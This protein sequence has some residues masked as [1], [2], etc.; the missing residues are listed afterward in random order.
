MT[1]ITENLKQLRLKKY[2]IAIEYVNS[3]L[4]KG[5]DTEP[6]KVP[7]DFLEDKLE[8]GHRI[9]IHEAIIDRKKWKRVPG[10]RIRLD[11]TYVKDKILPI[12]YDKKQKDLFCRILKLSQ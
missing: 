7:L 5:K 6:V 3:C 2:R 9:E 11:S 12:L 8:E 1:E 10:Y 4:E